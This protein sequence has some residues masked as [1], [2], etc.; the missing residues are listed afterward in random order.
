[1]RA[2]EHERFPSYR[3]SIEFLI[4]ADDIA[5]ALTRGRK[6]LAD[7]LQRAASSI[8]LNI[9]EGVGEY[10]RLEKVRFYR[11]ARRSATEC[12]AILDACRALALID[13]A[14]YETGRRLLLDL[15][16]LLTAIITKIAEAEEG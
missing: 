10:A 3:T 13:A 5:G 4:I 15:V 16:A 12:A 8:T 2:F 6:H 7:Q 9:A 1:M 14:Q 11:M